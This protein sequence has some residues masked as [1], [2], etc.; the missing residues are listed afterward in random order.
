ML[1]EPSLVWLG[2]GIITAYTTLYHDG[3]IK[4]GGK[5]SHH[6]K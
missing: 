6:A 5:A 4:V 1:H 2:L 3:T